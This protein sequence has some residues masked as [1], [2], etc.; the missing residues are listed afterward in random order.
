MMPPCKSDIAQCREL[1]FFFPGY[2]A[3]EELLV[4]MTFLR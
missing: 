1:A 3:T 4:I 2:M